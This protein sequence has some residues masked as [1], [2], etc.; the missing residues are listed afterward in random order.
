MDDVHNDIIK[1]M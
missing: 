1:K